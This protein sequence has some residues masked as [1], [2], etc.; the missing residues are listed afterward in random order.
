MRF[1]SL[2]RNSVIVKFI[3]IMLLILVVPFSI[4]IVVTSDKIAD[5]ENQSASQY[6]TSNLRTVSTTVDQILKDLERSHTTMFGN[7][8][9]VNAVKRLALYDDREAY[10]D[11][12]YTNEIKDGI[13]D[14]ALSNNYIYSVY[15]YCFKANRMFSSKITIS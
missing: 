13:T 10:S 9:F 2:P 1:R 4:L 7:P 14:T 12:K 3:S 6:L 8:R 15:T 5:T 11:F